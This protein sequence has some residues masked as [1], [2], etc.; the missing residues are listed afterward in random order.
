M[1]LMACMDDEARWMWRSL[2]V[3]LATTL[4]YWDV[5]DLNGWRGV[6][7]KALFDA[8]LDRAVY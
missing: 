8:L 6:I 3:N 2:L 4:L 5:N 1:T 7:C